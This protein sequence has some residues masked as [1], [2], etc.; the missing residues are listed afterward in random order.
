LPVVLYDCETWPLII[1]KDHRLKVFENRLLMGITGPKRDKTTGGWRKLHNEELH[2]S[3]S[4]L[5][6]LRMIK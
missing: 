4:W 1:R 3:Y 2:N 5:N 6:I